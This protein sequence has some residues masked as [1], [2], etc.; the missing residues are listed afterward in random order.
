MKKFLVK[1]IAR[2]SVKKLKRQHANSLANQEKIMHYLVKKAA[3]T[4]YGKTNGFEKINNYASFVEQTPLTNYHTLEP[5][6]Q[7]IRKGESNIFWPGKPAHIGKTSGTTGDFKYIP[8]S[9]E[10][11][12][13]HIKASRNSIFYYVNQTG[14]CNFINGKM[15]LLQGSPALE[16]VHGITTG[17]LSGIVAHYI[18]GYLKTNFL[19]TYATNALPD[20][21]QKIKE[22]VNETVN[23]DMR[24]FGGITSWMSNYM[25]ELL[26]KSGAQNLSQVY[27]NIQLLVLA[28]T[29]YEPYRQKFEFLIGKPIDVIEAYSATEGF[30]AYQDQHPSQGLLLNTN[31]GM[32]YEFIDMNEFDNENARRIWLKDVELEKNYALVI[33]TNSGLFGYKIG[34]TV[35]FVSKDPYRVVIT[36]RVKEYISA[37]GEQVYTHQTD[38]ALAQT[39]QQTGTVINEYHIHPVLKPGTEKS[40]YNW[41]IEFEKTPPDLQEFEMLLDKNMHAQN[42]YYRDLV[43]TNVIAKAKI[44]PVQKGQFYAAMQQLGKNGEQH[45]I[46]RLRH[47]GEFA[48]LLMESS[49]R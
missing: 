24:L 15:I 7:R 14:K 36:G 17:R 12:P 34:D 46:P 38:R 42:I 20:W 13:H 18:P 25:E 9:R 35:K 21:N 37:F 4:E 39:M 27:P 31:A 32:F 6:I 30:I 22:I 41:Y 28:G 16:N 1:H 2:L 10:A 47:D 43:V 48:K 45:K 33:S 11:M 40:H 5:F 19:P 3:T 23:A 26:K 8:I 29:S 49:T 44:V